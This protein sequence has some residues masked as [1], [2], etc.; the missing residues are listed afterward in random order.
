MAR[1]CL[2]SLSEHPFRIHEAPPVLRGNVRSPLTSQPLSCL[3]AKKAPRHDL[4]MTL[5]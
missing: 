4:P 3:V 1:H 5:K 2:V